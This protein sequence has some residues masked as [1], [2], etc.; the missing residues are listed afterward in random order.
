MATELKKAFIVEGNT[1]RCTNRE[2]KAEEGGHAYLFDI[3]IDFTGICEIKD[4]HADILG[5]AIATLVIRIQ[6]SLRKMKAAEVNLAHLEKE[7]VYVVKASD[8]GKTAI[9][10]EPTEAEIK[11]ALK[12][13]LAGMTQEQMMEYISTL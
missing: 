7:K 5:W 9:T 3:V 13:K 6:N 10:R 12:V 11:A 4:L 8:A 2:T 1:V